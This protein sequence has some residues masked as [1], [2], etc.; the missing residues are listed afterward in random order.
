VNGHAYLWDYGK[1]PYYNYSN[2]DKAQRL[3][4][5]YKFGNINANDFYSGDNL[6]YGSD[7]GIVE[8]ITEKNDFGAAYN[9][10]FVS[11][12]FDL[13]APHELKTF[14]ELY[15]SFSPDGNILANVTVQSQKTDSFKAKEYDI[16]SFSWAEFNWGAFTFNR[17]KFAKTFRFK[18]HLRRVE[19]L[20]IK[21]SGNTVNR[22]VGLSGLRF[23]YFVSGT[24]KE[25]K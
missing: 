7:L 18:L 11:K 13:D 6:Y 17:I 9:S 3:L 14:T 25:R 16:R 10:Y 24:T 8:F 20:Q 1:K 12:A 5:W 21:V 23:K 19:Y 4:A 22:G 15:P 2:Y